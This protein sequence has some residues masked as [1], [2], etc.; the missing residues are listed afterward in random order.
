MKTKIPALLVMT[1]LFLSSLGS[2]FAEKKTNEDPSCPGKGCPDVMRDK[3]PKEK[4][5]KEMRKEEKMDKGKSNAKEK[6]TS[7][8]KPEDIKPQKN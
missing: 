7:A 5:A 1:A 2:S 3:S 4:A 8:K 6:P